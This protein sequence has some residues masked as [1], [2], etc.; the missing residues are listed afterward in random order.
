MFTWYYGIMRYSDIIQ[1][2]CHQ[3][4]MMHPARPNFHYKAVDRFK[5][6]K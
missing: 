2:S 4:D 6:L 5:R 3:D 1:H